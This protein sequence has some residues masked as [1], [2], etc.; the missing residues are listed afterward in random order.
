MSRSGN[1]EWCYR[2]KLGDLNHL[3]RE[4]KLSD[5]EATT[6]ASRMVM[7]WSACEPDTDFCLE[8]EEL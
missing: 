6:I 1:G 7:Q 8:W 4:R 3:I 5:E 2:S